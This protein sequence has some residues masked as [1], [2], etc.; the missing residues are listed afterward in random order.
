MDEKTYLAS[1]LFEAAVAWLQEHY[2][3]REFWVEGDVVWT[4][5]TQLRQVVADRHL[6]WMVLNDYPM[7]PGPRRSLSADLVIRD[8]DGAV[9][10]AVEFKYEPSHQR[11]ELRA[12]PGKLPV[13]FWGSLLNSMAVEMPLL[14][15]TGF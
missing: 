8:V 3:E 7:L 11:T 4:V 5:Q 14:P 10:V 12:T 13:A 9:L 2:D 6:P 1:A 15:G